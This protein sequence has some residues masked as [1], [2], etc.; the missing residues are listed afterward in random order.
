[1]KII[2]KNDKPFWT[3]Q[4]TCSGE[5]NEVDNGRNKCL[6]CGSTLEIDANDIFITSHRCIDNSIDYYYSVKCPCCN[7]VTDLP[8]GK[9]PVVVQHYVH[10]KYKDS[11]NKRPDNGIER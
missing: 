2:K 9:L 5:G 3:M 7:C 10:A 4:L 11:K 1:M 6:P 8:E